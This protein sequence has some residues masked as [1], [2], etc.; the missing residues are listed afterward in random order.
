MTERQAAHLG[1]IK[2]YSE[3]EFSTWSFHSE[4][5]CGPRLSGLKSQTGVKLF[6][7]TIMKK[8]QGY[9]MTTEEWRLVQKGGNNRDCNAG[10]LNTDI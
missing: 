7:R 2:A 1:V 10:Q 4:S 5:W 8:F 9:Q 6:K 3:N